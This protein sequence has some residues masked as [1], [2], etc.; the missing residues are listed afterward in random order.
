MTYLELAGE[1]QPPCRRVFT[2]FS[3]AGGG[4]VILP[5]PPLSIQWAF[6]M[7]TDR[8]C[9]QSDSLVGRLLFT[10]GTRTN[11]MLSSDSSACRRRRRC[12]LS[13]A[14]LH[15]PTAPAA[16][17]PFSPPAS[18]RMPGVRSAPPPAPASRAAAVVLAVVRACCLSLLAA[19]FVFSKSGA[20]PGPIYIRLRGAQLTSWRSPVAGAAPRCRPPQCA[21]ALGTFSTTV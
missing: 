16:A 18:A 2:A 4:T 14:T 5:R 19:L 1:H 17:L 15:P 8:G 11:G 6:Q 21:C 9:Q 13:P 12:A 10:N 3:L 20:R 7:W